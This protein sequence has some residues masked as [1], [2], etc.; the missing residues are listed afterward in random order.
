MFQLLFFF[1][2]N[3][4]FNF[5]F[6]KDKNKQNSCKYICT[7][8]YRGNH[9][10]I[11]NLFF[12]FSTVQQFAQVFLTQCFILDALRPNCRSSLNGLSLRTVRRRLLDGLPALSE[13]TNSGSLSSV[14]FVYPDNHLQDTIHVI[15]RSFNSLHAG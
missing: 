12:T 8:L 10:V 9:L 11:G 15:D 4:I 7:Y 2:K 6:I 3:I 5:F 1:L 13:D 14:I